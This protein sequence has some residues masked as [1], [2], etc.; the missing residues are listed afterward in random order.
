MKYLLLLI[1]IVGLAAP[2]AYSQDPNKPD[3]TAPE[4]KLDFVRGGVVDNSLV[5]YDMPLRFTGNLPDD[6]DGKLGMAS[7]KELYMFYK[8]DGCS[9]F[10]ADRQLGILSS[11]Y[12]FV[13]KGS[14]KSKTL[15][16]TSST[17][18]FIFFGRD[19]SVVCSGSKDDIKKCQQR[20]FLVHD[21]N[22]CLAIRRTKDREV[23]EHDQQFITIQTASTFADHFKLDFGI[24]Y[25]SH[26]QAFVGTVSLH[27]Y[28]TPINESTDLESNIPPWEQIKRRTSLFV[29]I[30]PLTIH[31]WAKQEIKQVAN[32]GNIG[33][34]I[35]FRAPF[36][37]PGWTSNYRRFLQPMR[38]NVGLMYFAQ[39]DANPVIIKDRTKWSPFVSL[40]YDF[41][42]ASIFGPIAKLFGS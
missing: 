4:I 39:A 24:G 32:I 38:L 12:K 7:L 14:P 36:Y 11:D 15:F 27:A 35:G 13:G 40:T 30:I 19:L 18:E 31:S 42:I 29:S 33:F 16:G 34:G 1:I 28:L 3:P 20:H 17:I 22:Y 21:Q 2:Q 26:P 41:K 6:A 10:D 9:T 25:A 23:P 37:G 8:S 5:P